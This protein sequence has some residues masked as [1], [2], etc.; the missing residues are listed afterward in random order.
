MVGCLY[1]R[2]VICSF[3]GYSNACV[4]MRCDVESSH[5]NTTLFCLFWRYVTVSACHVFLWQPLLLPPRPLYS[6]PLQA[7]HVRAFSAMSACAQ[8]SCCVAM[9]LLATAANLV[10]CF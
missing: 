5:G 10:S 1:Q 8:T 7:F 9:H 6:M 2:S 3:H 4:Q